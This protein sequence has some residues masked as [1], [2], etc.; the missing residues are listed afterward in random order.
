MI[1]PRLWSIIFIVT[2]IAAQLERLLTAAIDEN[3][4]KKRW[5]FWK[6]QAAAPQK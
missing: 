5:Q 1:S 4:E 2:E 6:R 3:K